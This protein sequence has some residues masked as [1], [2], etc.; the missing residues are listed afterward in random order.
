MKKC[1]VVSDSFKGT[2]SS[3]EICSIARR[4]IPEYFPGCSVVA[5]PAA[6]GGEGTVDCMIKAL[7]AEPVALEVSGA[8]GEPCT[9]VYARLGDSAIVEMAS[10]AGLPSV[11]GRENPALT[12]TFGVGQL[13]GHAVAHGCRRLYLGLGGS[14]TNDGGCG[15][16]AALGVKFTDG[17]GREF[18]PV[19]ATL[20]DIASID[21]GGARAALKGVRLTV[22]SDVR[23]PL[24]GPDGAA[25][26]FGPQKG[27]DA[28]MVEALDAGLRHMSD[29]IARELGADVSMIPGAGAAGGMG[30]GAAAFLGA[31]LRSGIEAI[32]GLTGFDAEL[33]DADL[34]ITG[35]GRLDRQSLGGKVVSG[36]AAH[37]SAAGKP[38]VALVGCTAEGA[39]EVYGAGVSAVFTTNRACLPFEAL[40]ER[41]ADDYRAALRDLLSLIRLSER[42]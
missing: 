18:V 32:L 13:I 28:E 21:I 22:M 5:I 23:N 31:E 36:V 8:F 40:K 34:V 2:L 20:G 11:A 24:C 12:T 1:I 15:C 4:L 30:A 41:A 42:L 33:A 35:E 10:A 7:K 17:G 37:T 25:H 19:G 39:E 29:I 3:L 27:A 6:D 9:A 38:L 16:A 26:V 14:A